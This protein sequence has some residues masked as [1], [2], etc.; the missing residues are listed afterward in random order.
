MKLRML[1]K[2]PDSGF[3]GCPAVYAAP[4]DPAVM[5]VQGK[6]LDA[7]TTSQLHDLLTDETAVRIPAETVVRAVES[8]LAERGAGR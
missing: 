5:V 1:A 8:Y 7:D 2:D 3:G 4:D 6:V